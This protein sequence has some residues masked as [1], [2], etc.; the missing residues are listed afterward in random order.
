M[1]GESDSLELMRA[2]YAGGDDVDV[3]TC[4]RVVGVVVFLL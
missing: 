4:R 2:V 1:A 3:R